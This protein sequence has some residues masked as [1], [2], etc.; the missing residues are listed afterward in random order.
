MQVRGQP[1]LHSEVKVNRVTYV[2]KRKEICYETILFFRRLFAPCVLAFLINLLRV[3]EVGFFLFLSLHT[4]HQVSFAPPPVLLQRQHPE[5]WYN[6]HALPYPKYSNTFKE[7]I[8][9]SLTRLT[10]S[11]MCGNLC[12]LDVPP[13][14]LFTQ[15]SMGNPGV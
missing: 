6:W 13:M 8:P 12:F 9:F 2:E 14:T 10:E 7:K 15:A 5:C 11:G 1:G 4:P 3:G